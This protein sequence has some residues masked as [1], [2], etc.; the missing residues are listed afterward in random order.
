MV[1][2]TVNTGPISAQDRPCDVPIE[3][4]DL[5]VGAWRAFATIKMAHD[6]R[7][8]LRFVQ[9]ARQYDV[10]GKLGYGNEEDFIRN[11]L[12]MD[13]E[14]V[15]HALATLELVKPSWAL[16]FQEAVRL[17]KQG[18]DRKSKVAKDQPSN[19]RLVYGTTATY[20]RA[21]LDRDRPDL[22]EQVRDGKL[23]PHAAAITAGFRQ[24]T[25]TLPA[26]PEKCAAVLIARFPEVVR[27]IRDQSGK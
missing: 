22:A 7:E 23:S 17:G 10:I 18:G 26:D 25:I 16:P 4:W 9:E 24:R 15:R 14:A 3:K 2:V 20:T 1:A 5:L 12:G 11:G 19:I 21:R 8:L 27:L 13:P 6:C